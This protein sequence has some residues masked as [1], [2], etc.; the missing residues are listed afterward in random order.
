M[1]IERTYIEEDVYAEA[2]KRIHH[3]LDNFDICPVLFSGGKDSAVCIG[4]VREVKLERGDDTPVDVIFW[5]REFFVKQQVEFVEQVY[6]YEWVDMKWVCLQAP[7]PMFSFENMRTPISWEDSREWARQP[8]TYAIFKGQDVAGGLRTMQDHVIA[9]LFPAGATIAAITGVRTSESLT[10][11]RSVIN[12]RFESHISNSDHPAVMM[13]KPIY[14]WKDNDVYKYLKDNEF[15]DLPYVYQIN[16]LVGI[17]LRTSTVT[18]RGAAK[19]LDRLA[20]IDPELYENIIKFAPEVKLQ[21]LYWHELD[22]DEII[23]KYGGSYA[24]VR[25][26]IDK[27]V[28]DPKF[29]AQAI[30]TYEAAM[31][32][33]MESPWAY[34]PV[35]ML[36]HFVYGRYGGVIQPSS[37]LR[38]K[39]KKTHGLTDADLR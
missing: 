38:D 11:L 28:T 32:R 6:E 1:P 12:R 30:E 27:H 25:Y 16:Y 23:R 31:K 35:I 24:T 39:Y 8:P 14:D 29:H 2:K 4:L 33:A 34:S 13:C 21:A 17:G 10:R 26:Y 7:T 3:L 18:H 22:M 20:A 37:D 9:E 15:I 5:D 36:K 19:Y